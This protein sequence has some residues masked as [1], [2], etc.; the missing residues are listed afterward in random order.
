MFA[1]L[2]ELVSFKY[3]YIDLD[4]LRTTDAVIPI[5]Y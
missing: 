5:F 2:E 3:L 1:L 4:G